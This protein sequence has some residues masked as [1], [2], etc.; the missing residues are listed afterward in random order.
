MKEDTDMV[1]TV[2]RSLLEIS[3][4][5]TTAMFIGKL[6]V[7]RFRSRRTYGASVLATKKPSRSSSDGHILP[8]S[9]DG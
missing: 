9:I 3:A 6:Q 7:S 4:A 8:L 5:C 2:G 1:D